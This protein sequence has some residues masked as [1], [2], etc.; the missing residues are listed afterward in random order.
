MWLNPSL[1]FAKGD[2]GG[3][4]DSAVVDDVAAVADDDGAG[5]HDQHQNDAESAGVAPL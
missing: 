1:L 2:G 4:D 3:D 5:F